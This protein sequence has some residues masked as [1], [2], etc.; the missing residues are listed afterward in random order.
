MQIPAA[1]VWVKTVTFNI[2]GEE[3]YRVHG[4]LHQSQQGWFGIPTR[5]FRALC[6]SAS[7]AMGMPTTKAKLSV[8]VDPDGYSL[9]G[10]TPILRITKGTISPKEYE[11]RFVNGL[12]QTIHG[13]EWAPGWEATVRISYEPDR[14]DPDTVSRLMHYGGEHV[15]IGEGRR[16]RASEPTDYGRFQVIC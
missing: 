9:D 13:V 6:I 1:D 16:Q 4:P 8:L 2:R 7:N 5:V 14:I 15:G 10:E 12:S 11:I 3:P